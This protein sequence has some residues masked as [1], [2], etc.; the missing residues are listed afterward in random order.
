MLLI[1]SYVKY[2]N[3]MPII[4]RGT[5]YYCPCFADEKTEAQRSY[6]FGWG[7]TAHK[8]RSYILSPS[9]LTRGAVFFRLF[10]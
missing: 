3:S 10:F 8:E 7:Y 5:Y 1:P 9:S 2:F 6:Q 4:L